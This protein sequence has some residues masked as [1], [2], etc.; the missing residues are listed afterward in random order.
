MEQLQQITKGKTKEW[1]KRLKSCLQLLQLEHQEHGIAN[2]VAR[3]RD[4][5]ILVRL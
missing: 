1:R 3:I 2:I 4:G 5:L